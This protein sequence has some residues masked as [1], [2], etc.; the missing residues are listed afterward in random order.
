MMGSTVVNPIKVTK[1]D[2]KKMINA[3]YY[4]IDIEE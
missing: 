3:V 4:G 1:E 2:M